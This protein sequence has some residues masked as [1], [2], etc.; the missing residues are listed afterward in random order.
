[1]E[2]FNKA[3]TPIKQWANDDKP[4]EKMI[5]HGADALSAAELLAILINNGTKNKSAIDL[6]RELLQQADN[7]ISRLAKMSLKDVQKFK[8][9]GP[10][11]A[12]SIKAALQL[13]IILEKEALD[14]TDIMR[15]SKDIAQY[16]RK[17]LQ[18]ETRE[19]FVAVYLNRANKVLAM[20]TISAGGVTGTVADP[21]I[22][23]KRAIEEQACGIILSHNHPSGSLRPSDADRQLTEKIKA[24]AKLIDMTVVDHI[25]VS[26]Q[27]YYS[28]AD[29]G[30]I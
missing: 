24:A 5:K 18:H 1:M 2:N 21:R 30:E 19:L 6:A 29:S 26:D 14:D 28:F 15:S 11:K 4:R 3:H 7:K 8:G 12:V 23:L 27:G 9:I 25:I 13:G 17:K 22:I 20:E 16:L 10:A